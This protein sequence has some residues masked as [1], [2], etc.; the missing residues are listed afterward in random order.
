VK[1][2]MYAK[3]GRRNMAHNYHCAGLSSKELCLIMFHLRNLR[4]SERC[5]GKYKPPEK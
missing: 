2:E 5:F 1:K 3:S 4:F